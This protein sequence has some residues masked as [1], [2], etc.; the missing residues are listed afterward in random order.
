MKFLIFCLLVSFCL[1]DEMRYFRFR[2]G[3][4]IKGNENP[5]TLSGSLCYFTMSANAYVHF[6]SMDHSTMTPLHLMLGD[7]VELTT[8]NKVDLYCGGM[9]DG[10]KDLESLSGKAHLRLYS[11][12]SELSAECSTQTGDLWLLKSFNIETKK[13][14]YSQKEAGFRA[15][16][17]I[18]QPESKYKPP[19]V[20][21][22][23]IFDY[24]YHAFN[25][26][27]FLFYADAAGP[28]AGAIMLG[29]DGKHCGIL[30]DEGTKFIHTN[31]V[32]GKVTYESI[33]VAERY[34]SEGIMYKRWLDE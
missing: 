1:C 32:A 14:Y 21:S 33:A 15:K 5:R 24:P 28:E 34:F 30:D 26:E 12:G 3:T 27:S 19:N 25:C 11:D 18:G 23:A 10:A 22:F 9:R 7:R 29:K 20:I 8:A 6:Y 4:L 16:F 13:L 31:P 2:N 17:L